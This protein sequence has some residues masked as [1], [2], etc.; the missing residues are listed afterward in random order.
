MILPIIKYKN[1]KMKK[2]VTI[3]IFRPPVGKYIL[4]FPAGLLES[5]DYMN[6]A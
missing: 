6:E 5:T 3:A 1:S 2:L 4:G